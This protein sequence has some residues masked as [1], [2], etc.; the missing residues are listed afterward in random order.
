M[1]DDRVSKDAAAL[2]PPPRSR[3]HL[4]EVAGGFLPH[5][6]GLA[7]PTASC[8]ICSRLFKASGRQ[9]YCS[10]ACR[11]AAYRLRREPAPDS[12]L[13]EFVR[14][15]RRR[16]ALVAHTVYECDGCGA[17]LIGEWRCPECNLMCKKV[18]P[19]GC[20]PHCYEAVLVTELLE[21]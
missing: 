6:A 12:H 18:G 9:L 19:G 15:L 21:S 4:D 10:R 8:A 3:H 16:K 1:C 14:D 11:Q 2:V 13:Q 20:C 17:R 7:P 5:D